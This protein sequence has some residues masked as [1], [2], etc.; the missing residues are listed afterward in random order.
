MWKN[1]SMLTISNCRLG[2]VWTIIGCEVDEDAEFEGSDE[3]IEIVDWVE[4]DSEA[5]RLKL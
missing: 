2:R 5:I 3:G 4:D 1:A